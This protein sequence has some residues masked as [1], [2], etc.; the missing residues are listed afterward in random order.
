MGNLYIIIFNLVILD[1]N[2]HI[3]LMATVSDT[4]SIRSHYF[5]YSVN[6]KRKKEKKEVH[7]F[8][9]RLDVEVALIFSLEFY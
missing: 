1:L 5:K 4:A 7:F 6:G 2:S 9:Q 8:F 3:W